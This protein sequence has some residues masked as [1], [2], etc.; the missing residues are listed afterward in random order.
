VKHFPGEITGEQKVD[1]AGTIIE[2]AI[3]NMHKEYVSDV[4]QYGLKIFPQQFRPLVNRS[5]IAVPLFYEGGLVG[6]FGMVSDRREFLDSR[7]IGLIELMC[8]QA[9]TS[10]AN[11]RMH[12]EIERMATT[13]GLTGLLNHRI[14]QE[15]MTDELKRSERYSTP[16]SLLLTDIDHFKKVND[17]Y[18]HP[19]GDIV[20]RGVAGI[21]KREI[22]DIDIAARYG[23]EE[24]AVILP[25]TDG[26]GAKII[27]ERLRNAIKA[28]T[29]AAGAKTLR[30]STSIGIA[31]A[32]SDAR[33]KEELIEKADQALY[34]A[35][36]HGRDQSASWSARR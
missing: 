27:A 10:I 20:L 19:V 28:E 34:H 12:A 14:F 31:T 24:F 17:T 7:Q 5:V 15:K 1:F 18:G 32:P 35:K 33:T 8:N 6:V 29:F 21:L 25:E 30:V 22:R 2:L 4:R 11:A 3:D 16:V 13:D 9:A 23:G 36:H 26:A